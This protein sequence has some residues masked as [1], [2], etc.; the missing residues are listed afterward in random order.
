MGE[1]EGNGLGGR[2]AKFFHPDGM[3]SAHHPCSQAP[4]RLQRTPPHP[5]SLRSPPS[6]EA[7]AEGEER[8]TG[9]KAPASASS[10]DH[11]APSSCLPL[12]CNTSE[13]LPLVHL[14]VGWPCQQR[15]A[16]PEQWAGQA[17]PLHPGGSRRLPQRGWASICPLR[18][19]LCPDPEGRVGCA[20]VDALLPPLPGKEQGLAQSIS[21]PPAC[22]PGPGEFR[23]PSLQL[24]LHFGP[25][26]E[27]VSVAL[28]LGGR[29]A[30][31]WARQGL[32][33]A[34]G[35]GDWAG[36]GERGPRSASLLGQDP[37]LT[38]SHE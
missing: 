19:S 4:H 35:G 30:H 31:R 21:P 33:L 15:E 25:G 11:A 32:G 6:V 29:A 3:A 24:Q 14:R 37:S 12:S 34:A 18:Y 7:P 22:P 26:A 8:D 17:A 9:R 5:Q 38:Q 27:P 28:S 10:Q 23:H 1:A 2:G 13:G 20:P 36:L 16:R